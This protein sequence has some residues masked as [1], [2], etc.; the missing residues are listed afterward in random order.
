MLQIFLRSRRWKKENYAIIKI[1]TIS[2]L[3]GF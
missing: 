2:K 3:K 1:Q